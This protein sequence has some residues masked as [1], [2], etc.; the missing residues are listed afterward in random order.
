MPRRWS[1]LT[2]VERVERYTVL[3][4]YVV[5][6]GTNTL[7]LLPAAAK[8]DDSDEAVALLAGGA[9]VTALGFATARA[10]LGRLPA[11]HPLPWRW[12]APLLAASAVFCAVAPAAW[13]EPTSEAALIAVV[14]SV[15]LAL[16]LLPGRALALGLLL[17]AALVLGISAGDA[18]GVASGLISAGVYLIAA[19]ASVWLLRI[20]TELDGARHAQAQLA[21]AEERLRFSRDVHDILGRRLATIAIQAELA[22]TLAARGDDRGADRMLEV[23][24]VAHEALREARELARGYRAIDL[25]KELDGARSLLSSAGIEVRLDVDTVPRAWHEAAGWIVR[26]GVT[27]VLRHSTAGVAEIAYADGVLRVEND[28]AGPSTSTDGS[29]LR[30]LRERLAPLGASIVAGSDGD[31][32]WAVVAQLPGAGPLSARK[33]LDG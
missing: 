12:I 19:R 20:V 16:G 3:S 6:W 9:V 31:G 26:E 1:E 33:D 14:A 23:R 17:G 29:G 5:L 24:S 4:L 27:N 28:G 2:D 18:G 25:A 7:T 13:P 22:A 10:V 8:L 32:R 21:V 15:T 11:V 30:G